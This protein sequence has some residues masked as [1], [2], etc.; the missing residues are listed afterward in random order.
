MLVMSQ[1]CH[2]SC[3]AS[4]SLDTAGGVALRDNCD[5]TYIYKLNVWYSICAH[6]KRTRIFARI[7]FF[8]HTVNTK[9]ESLVI[10][11]VF[12]VTNGVISSLE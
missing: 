12:A 9:Q 4:K 10:A 5:K 2:W 3:H 7:G 8:H 1:C 6:V 11:G